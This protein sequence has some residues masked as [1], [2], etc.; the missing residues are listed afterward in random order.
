M[1]CGA[2]RKQLRIIPAS[3][4]CKYVRQLVGK[5]NITNNLD[6]FNSNYAL[7]LN[8]SHLKL[9]LKQFILHIIKAKLSV[10]FEYS[11]WFINKL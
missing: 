8:Y 3:I 7:S 2:A 9:V 5:R 11:S 10:G 4:R 6:L 1:V